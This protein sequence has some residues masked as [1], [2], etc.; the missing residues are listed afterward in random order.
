MDGEMSAE[1]RRE[2][3]RARRRE[4]IENPFSG[5]AVPEKMLDLNFELGF[6]WDSSDWKYEGDRG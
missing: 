2:A 3:R 5:G 4:R 1:E 6:H